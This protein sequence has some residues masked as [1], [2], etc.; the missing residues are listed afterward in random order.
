MSASDQKAAVRQ[1]FQRKMASTALRISGLCH[2]RPSIAPFNV[3]RK[4]KYLCTARDAM[5]NRVVYWTK[6]RIGLI[7]IVGNGSIVRADHLV[8]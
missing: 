2:F 7:G 3:T 6:G 4:L 1:N 8:S 5:K